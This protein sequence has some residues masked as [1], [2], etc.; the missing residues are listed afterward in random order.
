MNGMHTDSM[1]GTDMRTT[2]APDRQTG[3]IG[4]SRCARSS[5]RRI[6]WLDELCGP[7]AG[8]AVQRE[9]RVVLEKPDFRGRR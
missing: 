3:A 4:V 6:A 7:Q 9:R 1:I 5:M 8:A 2:V